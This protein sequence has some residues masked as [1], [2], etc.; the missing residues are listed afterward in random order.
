[1]ADGPMTAPDAP[2][3]DPGVTPGDAQAMT[4][5]ELFY[6][7]RRMNL[8][9][10]DLLAGYLAKTKAVNDAL[11]QGQYRPGEN[12]DP[13][14]QYPRV[15]ASFI[16]GPPQGPFH[17]QYEEQT[18]GPVCMPVAMWVPEPKVTPGNIDIGPVDAANPAYYDAGP[19]DGVSSNQVVTGPDG[20]KYQKIG[21]YLGT[22][23]A[24]GAIPGYY[25]VV[26]ESK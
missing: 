5:T 3:A 23:R 9:N 22:N 7:T 6:A 16:L 8:K 20:R 21:T 25:L 2:P 4:D 18:G 19:R 13:L 12:F 1:M 10:A 17:Y 14:T 11:Q 24:T 26:S 15:P